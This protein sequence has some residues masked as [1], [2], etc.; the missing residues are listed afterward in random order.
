MCLAR[1]GAMAY[2]GNQRFTQSLILVI[3]PPSSTAVFIEEV[4]ECL[5]KLFERYEDAVE[6]H[7]WAVHISAHGSA[8]EMGRA[9]V[10]DLLNQGYKIVSST[11]LLTVMSLTDADASER[12]LIQQ[13]GE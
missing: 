2:I 7:A 3:Y 6:N 12:P 11:N 8:P 9:V 10:L 4:Q 5:G 1:V 13:I